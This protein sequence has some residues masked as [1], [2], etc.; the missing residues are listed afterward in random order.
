MH[1]SLEPSGFLEH[2]PLPTIELQSLRE[3]VPLDVGSACTDNSLQ[4]A[5]MI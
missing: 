1:D 3:V 5:T 2:P 4:E